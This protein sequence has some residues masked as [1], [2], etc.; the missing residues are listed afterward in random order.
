PVTGLASRALQRQGAYVNST[1]DSAKLTYVAAIEPIW[2]NFSVSQNQMAKWSEAQAKGELTAP[3]NDNFDVEIALPGGNKYPHK[4]KI[5]FT[6]PSFS[7]D[8]GTFVVRAVLPNPKQ[9]P[10]QGMVVTAD[11]SRATRPRAS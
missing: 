11:V 6:D 5:S 2:V 10:R 9:D 4:G 7:Q 3:P 1:A 8:T